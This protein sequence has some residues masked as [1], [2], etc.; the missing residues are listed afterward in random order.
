MAKKLNSIGF[1]PVNPIDVVPFS[2]DK[3]WDDYMK[4]D[5]KAML[6]CNAVLMLSD[7]IY[8]KGADIERDFA[9]KLKIPVYYSLEDLLKEK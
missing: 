3:T 8:S 4:G 5:L 1:N 7:W 9:L 6:D 2:P